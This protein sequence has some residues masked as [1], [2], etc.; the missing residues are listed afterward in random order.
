[1]NNIKTLIS[2]VILNISTFFTF[3]GKP[4]NLY[5]N[6]I[7]WCMYSLLVAL[8]FYLE[9]KRNVRFSRN[10]VDQVL[11]LFFEKIETIVKIKHV[12]FIMLPRTS[13]N[14]NAILRN[15]KLIITNLKSIYPF[16]LEQEHNLKVVRPLGIGI[17]SISFNTQRIITGDF[18]KAKEKQDARWGLSLS[19]LVMIEHGYK[20][21]LAIPIIDNQ[22]KI[23]KGVLVIYSTE[24]LENTSLKDDKT[25]I[26]IRNAINQISPLII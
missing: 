11:S 14:L 21:V 16:D 8:I 10:V 4:E 24:L 23:A 18:N 9:Q 26:D 2:I 13:I 20:S 6:I 15:E 7:F 19:E 22:K 5:K 1:M 3:L 17:E 12:A 25:H